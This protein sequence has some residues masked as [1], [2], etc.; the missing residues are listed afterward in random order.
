MARYR[1]RHIQRLARLCRLR[2]IRVLH[3]IT[4]RHL[5]LNIHYR[6]QHNDRLRFCTNSSNN[7]NNNRTMSFHLHW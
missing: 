5:T 6:R 7:N 4:Y 3:L 2:S 1:L